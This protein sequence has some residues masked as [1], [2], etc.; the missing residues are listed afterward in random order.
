M[1]FYEIIVKPLSGLGTPLKGDTLFGHVC[2]QARYDSMLLNGGLDKWIAAYGERPFAVFSSAWPKLWIEGKAF[3]ALK[4][5]DL[6][7]SLLFPAADKNRKIRMA[8]RK[9]EEKKKW[10]LVGEDLCIDLKAAEYKSESDLTLL[11]FGALTD[12]TRRVMRGRDIKQLLMTSNQP[13]NTID[14]ETQT[15]GEGMFAPFSMPA[16]YFYPELELAVFVLIDEEATDIEKVRSA[17]EAIGARGF[18]RDASTGLGRFDLGDGDEI[19]VPSLEGADACY[20]LAPAV[21]QKGLFHDSSFTPFTRFGRHGDVLAVS[22]APFKN[23]VIMADEGA[24]FVPGDM[25]VFDKPYLGSAVC[26]L[27]KSDPRTVAQGYAPYLPLK[28]EA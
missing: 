6:P 26:N 17:L 23:P 10:L 19:N 7:L 1:K 27:S 12:E 16:T 21:P 28:L 5:P 18:G 3:Y 25:A 20:T 13:H 2:W 11:A 15:T 22:A 14:R 24:V 4:R 8:D 9:E